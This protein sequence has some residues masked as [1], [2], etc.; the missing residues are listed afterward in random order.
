MENQIIKKLTA[1]CLFY[2]P[3]SP[4]YLHYNICNCLFWWY[5]NGWK[6]I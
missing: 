5:T 3:L 2:E 4:L 6:W 1:S